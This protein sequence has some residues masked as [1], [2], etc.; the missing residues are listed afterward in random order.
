MNNI[1]GQ[2]NIST[3]SAHLTNPA[4]AFAECYNQINELQKLI[5]KV[6]KKHLKKGNNE[7]L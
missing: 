7:H 5:S 6:D 3:V 2:N 4:R 1:C